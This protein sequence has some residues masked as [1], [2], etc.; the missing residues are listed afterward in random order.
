MVAQLVLKMHPQSE[1]QVKNTTKTV[2]LNV[3]A[4]KR[5][6]MKSGRKVRFCCSSCRR[7]C[8]GLVPAEGREGSLTV[9]LSES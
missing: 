8:S 6:E 1:I 5:Q 9:P 3:F 2:W 4:A 7:R